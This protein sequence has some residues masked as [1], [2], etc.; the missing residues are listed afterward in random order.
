M[1][2]LQ[3]AMIQFYGLTIDECGGNAIFVLKLD[4]CQV[5]KGQGLQRV[6]VTLMN[7][8]LEGHHLESLEEGQN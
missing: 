4:E 6:S 1:E 3:R 2:A 8:A 7:R 5:V